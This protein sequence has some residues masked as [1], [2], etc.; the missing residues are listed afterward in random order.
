MDYKE[1]YEQGLECIQEILSSGQEKIKMTLLKERLQP[2]FPELGESEDE[3]TWLTKFIEEEAYSLSMDIRGNEDRIKLKN[4][5][6]SL[7]WLEKQKTMDKE[8]VFRPLIGTDIRVAA[9]QALEKIEIGKKVVLAF[10]GAYIP[11]NDKTVSKICDEYD[12]WIEKQG[13]VDK[14]SYEIAEKEKY[15]FVSGKFI[16]CRKSFD[17]FKEDNSYWLEYVGNDTYIG[18]SDN[19]L[20]KS[21]HITPRQ[22]YCLFTQEHHPKEN[23]VDEE[24]NGPT[25]Y[26]KYVDECLN[27]AA[28]HFFSKGEDNYSVADLFYAG[29]KCGQSW[30]E[31]QSEQKPIM[32]VPTREVILAIWDLGN[33]WEELTN[34]VISTKYGTQLDYIQKHWHESEYYLREKQGEQ[35]QFYI[36]FGDIPK[37]EKS[38]VWRGDE[39]IGKENGVSVYP[40]FKHNG[41][42]V[43]GLSLPIT[44]TTL[45]TL[46]HLL[47]YDNRPC[48]LVVGDYI[49]NGADGEPLIRNVEIVEEIKDFRVKEGEERYKIKN[50]DSLSVNGQPFDHEKATITQKDF[51]EIVNA[52]KDTSILDMVEPKFK[53]GDFILNGDVTNDGKPEIFKIQKICPNWYDAENI[54][55]GRK[56]I[57]TFNQ[58]W[59]CK[60]WNIKDAE[61]GD[62][63]VD[64]LSG[65]NQI[66]ILFKSIELDAS[67]RA[68]CGWNHYYFR[69]TT[70]GTGYGTLSSTKY[71]PATKEQHDL[72]FQKMEEEG[73]EWDAENKELKKISSLQSKFKVGDWV[74]YCGKPYQITGLH[75]DV[76]TLTSCN[77]SYFFNDVKNTKEPFFHIWT[78][79]DA[80]D[81][82]VIACNEEIL[83]FKSYSVQGRISVYCWYNGQTNNFHSIEVTDASLT[84]RN[85]IWPATKEQ[86][87]T[88]FKAM[89]EAGYQWDAEKKEL[90]LLISNGGDF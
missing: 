33:E 64:S 84:T 12:A 27:D 3:L 2:F 87:D 62:V 68:Y 41:N 67:I 22:L 40:A 16:E 82:D 66:T 1:K 81:G 90:K 30:L 31:E 44:K 76:F 8:I 4:L 24:T 56:T 89:T 70:D 65:D 18:R 46:Q 52:V 55:D 19:I 58:E 50:S 63:L 59:S 88:L 29:V 57:I 45:H 21:F 37:G 54:Y 34:G 71:V 85:K 86:R 78:I 20:N 10:N 72:L 25:S 14:T 51:E 15:D 9:K 48:Y 7:A 6:K 47:E 39:F 80:K 73:Y 35:K 83:L 79:D 17:E 75:N 38:S 11:V 13:N 74:K 23:N 77:G 36:R 60:L 43:L 69:V 5:Q 32:N 49:G 26:G 42:I 28:K 61:D 53:V